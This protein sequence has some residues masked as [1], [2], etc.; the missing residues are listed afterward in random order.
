M[1]SHLQDKRRVDALFR[2][3]S[4]DYL[5]REQFVTDPAQILTEYTSGKRLEPEQAEVA[6]HLVYAMVSNEGLLDWMTS[7][8]AGGGTVPAGEEF[9]ADFVS[10]VAR[11]GDKQTVAAIVRAAA[12][13]QDVF[14]VQA[15]VVRNLILAVSTGR[16]QVFSGTEMSSPGTE[17]SPGPGTEMSPGHLAAGAEELVG[18]QVFA[19]T[20]M[21]SPGT[22]MSPGRV[23]AGTEMSSP[24]TEMSPGQVFAG[25]EMSSPGTEMSPGRVFAGTEMSSP[26]TEMSPGRVFAGTE[27]SSPGTEMSPGQ[28]FA[29]TEMSS[30]GTEISPG[31]GTNISPGSVVG[32]DFEVALQ[33]LVGFATQ[34]RQVGALNAVRLR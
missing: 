3:L 15:E 27:M 1:I 28:V 20:E 30:P 24:G 6:N 13:D 11:H 23:F 31:H 18:G 19:G 4:S 12:K 10:A 5:L 26:G 2:V 33:A 16:G 22:E 8:A 17:I 7:Y 29:G 9:A 14:T 21:S 34:L 25:T 32:I